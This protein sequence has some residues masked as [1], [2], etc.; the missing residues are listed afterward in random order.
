MKELVVTAK[1]P[2]ITGNFEEV[3]KQ[4]I[5]GVKQYDVIIT[6][7]TVKDGKAMATEINKMKGL[8]KEVQK[9]HLDT[10]TGPIA[11]FK[12]QIKELVDIAE[13]ARQKI[14][15]QVKVFEDKERELHLTAL[16]E[17]LREQITEQ[18]IAEK[19]SCT[20]SCQEFVSI[21]GLTKTGSLTKKSRDQI[22]LIV[23]KALQLQ[24]ADKLEEQQRQHDEDLRVEKRAQEIAKENTPEVIVGIAIEDSVPISEDLHR[25]DIQIDG[26]MPTPEP[27][28]MEE[29]IDSFHLSEQPEQTMETTHSEGKMEFIAQINILIEAPMNMPKELMAQAVFETLEA[30]GVEDI[31]NIEIL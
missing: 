8:I 21:T 11:E 14:L 26:H 6:S 16:H 31:Q 1:A 27:N 7:D 15:S 19:Y 29:Q 3:K 25:V 23:S 20:L 2:V 30:Q 5:E 17:Y 4:M 28:V 13:D 9:N 12:D 24:T 10:L 18:E 22:D